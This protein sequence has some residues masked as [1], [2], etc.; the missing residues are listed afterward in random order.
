M[1]DGIIATSKSICAHNKSTGL[2]SVRLTSGF[3]KHQFDV[4]R[5]VTIPHLKKLIDDPNGIG[6]IHNFE[7]KAG[8]KQGAFYGTDWQDEMLYKWMEAV[9]YVY[10]Q[11]K[12]AA[13][14]A[15]LD[16]V[17]ALIGNAQDADGY[18]A[19]QILKHKQRYASPHNHE[20]YV[21]GHGITA[22]CAHA[23]I[24]GSNT[25]LAVAEKIAAHLYAAFMPRE[26]R[27]AH[28]CINPSNIMA[29]V[30]LYRVTGVQKHLDLANCFIDMRGSAPRSRYRR[31][32]DLN[33]SG[34]ERTG[35]AR[36]IEDMPVHERPIPPT[37][38]A[39]AEGSDL[40][41]TRIPLRSDTEVAGHSVFWSYLYA[42]AAD[43]FMETGDASLMSALSRLWDDVSLKKLYITGGAAAVH[44][45]FYVRDGGSQWHADDV[46][47]AV[48]HRYDLP[49]FSAYNETCAQIGNFMWNY[50]MFLATG[51]AKHLDVMENTVYN[52]II[53]GIG[54]DGASWFYTNPL[55]WNG[56]DHKLL[57]QD[58]YER[59]QP[60][61]KHIC[62]PSNLVRTIAGF[63][64]YMYT[65]TG[66]GISAN[67]YG[68]SVFDGALADGTPVKITQTTDYPWDGAI[69]FTFDS[70]SGRPFPFSMRIPEWAEGARIAVNGVKQKKRIAS[71]MLHAITRRWKSGDIVELVLPM[72][73]RLMTAH[74]YV[75]SA[76]NQVT[77]ARGPV[78]YCLE[79]PDLPKGMDISRVRIPRKV[80]FSTKY[81][82][83]LLDGVMTLSADAYISPKQDWNG[84]LYQEMP[85]GALKKA[86]IRLI[87]Y[88]AWA[89]RG[90]SKMTVWL[91]TA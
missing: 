50:R 5:T 58:S 69:R 40:N 21:M 81:E 71:G 78:I 1:M 10:A 45:G 54:R 60:G 11:T 46:H 14:P 2:A 16:P 31:R 63:H 87:P 80:K 42:G 57:S 12:D 67:L 44:R 86:R 72:R 37:A 83:K 20:L 51:D 8:V 48:G 28:F 89:N 64:G 9:C 17:I 41:Q 43:A 3:W 24:T 62:C 65:L 33:D 52:S 59:F 91:P 66:S 19:T 15:M 29:L 70:A 73:V 47:E 61:V 7:V 13:L 49:S 36:Y 25:F 76:V 85:A 30:E 34:E 23:R 79:S 22:A 27:Y 56:K 53:S 90:V 4:C 18:L 75:E 68:A 38:Q 55:R 6:C 82:P 84:T 74:P 35:D 88:F 39:S 32:G 77:I 26:T